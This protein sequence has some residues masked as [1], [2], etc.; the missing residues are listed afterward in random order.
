MGL[1]VQRL[2]ERAPFGL[3]V[4]AADHA[5]GAPSWMATAGDLCPGCIT[6]APHVR[7]SPLPVFRLTSTCYL[8]VMRELAPVAGPVIFLL[9]CSRR[10]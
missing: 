4:L 7:L 10:A 5:G 1:S 2:R 6:L 3:D 9:I 8:P